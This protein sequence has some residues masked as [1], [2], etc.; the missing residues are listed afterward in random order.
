ME[1]KWYQKSYFRNLVDMHINNGDE[2]LLASF[3]AEAYAENMKTAGF[4]TA[5]IYASNCLGLCLFPTKNGYRHQIAKKRDIFGET[6]EACRKRGIR[7]VGYLNHWTTEAYNHHPEWRVVGK[8]GSGS[9]DRSGHGGR[10]GICCLNSPYRDYFLSLVNELCSNYPIEGLWVDM[11]GFW[12]DA[13]YCKTC[14]EEYRKATGENIPEVIDWEAPEWRRY[15][16]FKEESLNRYARDIVRTAKEAW[17]EITVSIQC[18]SWS[19]GYALGMNSGFFKE[20]DYSAGDFYTDVRDQNVDCKFLR[21]VTANQPFEYM[22]PRCPDLIYHTVSKPMWVIRQQAYS[23]F[24]H[25]GA[26][27]CIDAIDPAGTLNEEVYRLFGQVR[28]ELE[29]YWEQPSFLRGDYLNDMAVYMNYQSMID[30]NQNGKSTDSEAG[31]P[32]LKRLKAINQALSASHIQYDII[33][34]RRLSELDRYPLIVISELA[35]LTQREIEAFREYVKNGGHLYVSGRSGI[36]ND[37]D[38][39]PEN[40][41][42]KRKDF[43]LQDIMGVSLVGTIPYHCV[44]MKGTEESELF[45]RNQMRYPLSTGGPAPMV[46]A[47]E[48]TKVLAVAQLPVSNNEDGKTFISAISD[49]PWNDTDIPVL[50][51]HVYGKGKCVYSALLPEADSTDMVK[52]LWLGIVGQLLC[53]RRKVQI[54]APACVEASVKNVDGSICISL[55]HTLAHETQSP[56]GCVRIRISDELLRAGQAAC[57]PSGQITLEKGQNE[58]VICAAELPEFTVI[59]VKGE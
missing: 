47:H 31:M 27:L 4:D 45:S 54:E 22:V 25:G 40:G 15:V 14:Q 59:T 43:A 42:L 6:V 52:N 49:P 3:D 19:Q 56:A 23:A 35:V 1:Q 18:A 41:T 13:C 38:V 32:L 46:T 58:T 30:L 8:D 39:E 10:Y 53:G 44:Y 36:I 48:D 9:R 29:P 2:R 26:F 7:P 33:T 34:D 28:K 50:T 12:R 16:K 20:F 17:P 57:F 51:E 5:Y 21:G 24:L 55:L 11:V 37:L